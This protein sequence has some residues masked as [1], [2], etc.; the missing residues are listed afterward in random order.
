[1]S[2]CRVLDSIGLFSAFISDYIFVIVCCL[3]KLL[4]YILNLTAVLT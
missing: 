4:L 2:L 1:M 3:S